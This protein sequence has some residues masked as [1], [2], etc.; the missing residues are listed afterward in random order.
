MINDITIDG[1][2]YI[3]I[4]KEEARRILIDDDYRSDPKQIPWTKVA[5][6]VP[7][8]LWNA[9]RLPSICVEP[10][11]Q[12]SESNSEYP[13]IQGNLAE[14]NRL[15]M[16][17]N[18]GNCE[19]ALNIPTLWQGGEQPVPDEVRVEVTYRDGSIGTGSAGVFV[20][21]RRE[22]NIKYGDIISYKIIGLAEGWSY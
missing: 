2:D 4:P 20:W 5:K 22:G 9:E 15:N 11:Y 1:K 3:V 14:G 13:Y 17:M 21:D 10:F 16:G 6:G 19:L 12:L 7:C 8:V 18:Y